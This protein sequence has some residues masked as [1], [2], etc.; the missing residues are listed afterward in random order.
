[1]GGSL[2]MATA[3]TRGLEMTR[4]ATTSGSEATPVG[5][6]TVSEN[7]SSGLID[8]PVG[9]VKLGWMAVA[10]LKA[11]SGRVSCVHA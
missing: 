2:A 6:V 1:M 5:S 3:L 8:S 10:S 11:T 7:L 9:A 4:M